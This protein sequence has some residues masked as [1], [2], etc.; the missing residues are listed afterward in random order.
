[1]LDCVN[2]AESLKIFMIVY[3][4]N[5][6]RYTLSYTR[7]IQHSDGRVVFSAELRANRLHL[8]LHFR[9][10]KHLHLC[11]CFRGMPRLLL[12]QNQ[13]PF[14]T[15]FGNMLGESSAKIKE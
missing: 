3:T 1:M 8:F 6:I 15:K 11:L 13:E 14:R 2:V 12:L 10:A 9:G 7:A 4:L 5:M